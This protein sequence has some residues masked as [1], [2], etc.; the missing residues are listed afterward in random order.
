MMRLIRINDDKSDGD[1][2]PDKDD[3]DMSFGDREADKDYK[4][5]VLN[6]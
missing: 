5:Y 1:N 2:E 3:D 4:E 6:K